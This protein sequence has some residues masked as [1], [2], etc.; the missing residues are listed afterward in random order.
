LTCNLKFGEFCVLNKKTKV[1]FGTVIH[2]SGG[3]LD[4]VHVD[5]WGPTKT[6]S[7][8]GHQYLISFVDDSSRRCWVY[9]MR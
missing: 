1:R 8:G 4:Y 7:L 9:L 3:L 6:A 5:I 2:C